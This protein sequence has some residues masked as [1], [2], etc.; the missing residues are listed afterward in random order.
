MLYNVL[1]LSLRFS[2]NLLL[3]LN[4][5]CYFLLV[6]T[7]FGITDDKCGLL[8]AYEAID[9]MC[10]AYGMGFSVRCI[11]EIVNRIDEEVHLKDATKNEIFDICV[12]NTRAEKQAFFQRYRPTMIDVADHN[13]KK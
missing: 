3:I 8:F 7:A 1:T 6:E 10:A 5:T 12:R 11:D 2:S 9:R 4:V 13:T